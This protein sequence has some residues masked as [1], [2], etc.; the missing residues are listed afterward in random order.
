MAASAMMLY[1]VMSQATEFAVEFSFQES[2]I[3]PDVIST[4]PPVAA[5]VRQSAHR[6]ATHA[7]MEGSP[8]V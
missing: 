2:K 3:V 6:L 1:L 4:A 8:I 7:H 5:K